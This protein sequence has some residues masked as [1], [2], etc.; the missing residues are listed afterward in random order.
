MIKTRYIYITFFRSTIQVSILY[1]YGHHSFWIFHIDGLVQEKRH[2]SALAME[3]RLSCT[4]PSIWIYQMFIARD[5]ARNSSIMVKLFPAFV[6]CQWRVMKGQPSGKVV[7]K[8]WPNN[9]LLA[10]AVSKTLDRKALS[11]FRATYIKTKI[12][13][14][15]NVTYF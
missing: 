2:S 7:V 6:S 5:R 12:P 15:E 4:K 14:F 10:A 1:V 3:L 13:Y 8:C 11:L 9:C